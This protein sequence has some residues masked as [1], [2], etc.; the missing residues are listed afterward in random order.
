MQVRKYIFLVILSVSSFWGGCT[1]NDGYI[2]D[3]WGKWQL[4]QIIQ[5]GNT[6]NVDT[7][8]YNFQNDIISLQRLLLNAN[9]PEVLYGQFVH[10]GDSLFIYMRDELNDDRMPLFGLNSRESRLKVKELTSKKLIL[11]YKDEFW[12]LRKY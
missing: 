9:P 11:N 2:G 7:I 8:F 10:E 5:N 4:R 1:Q 3:L 6:Q 12:I